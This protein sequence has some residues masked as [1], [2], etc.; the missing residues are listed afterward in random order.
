MFAQQQVAAQ[1]VVE[2]GR[3]DRVVLGVAVGDQVR[4]GQVLAKIDDF[5]ARQ[6]LRQ[7]QAGLDGQEAAYQQVRDNTAVDGAGNSVAQARRI[8]QATEDQ[9]DATLQADDDAIHQAQRAVDQ[10][11]AGAQQAQAQ[12]QAYNMQCQGGTV[13]GATP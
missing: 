6:A 8:V 10:A 1:H 13:P 12:Y 5:G 3:P 7:A 4:A 9:V 2:L 11:K